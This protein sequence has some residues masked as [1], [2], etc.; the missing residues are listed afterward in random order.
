MLRLTLK[1]I[2]AIMVAAL[3]GQSSVVAQQP[4]RSPQQ[5]MPQYNT[6]GVST[7][8]G[9]PKLDAPLYSSPVQ[10][11]PQQMGGAFITNQAFA[12]HEMLYPHKYKAI[13]GP[14]YYKVKGHY[15]ITRKGVKVQEKW[16]L[17]GTEVEVE[18]KDH[19]SVFD[20][21]SSR[22]FR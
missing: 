22:L 9:Y 19:F 15:Y 16:Y 3:I 5:P 6:Y 8:R 12:P 17:K 1:T 4:E 21:V 10:Y 11:V 2:A 13:Y 14:F 20:N 7:G 18:Y